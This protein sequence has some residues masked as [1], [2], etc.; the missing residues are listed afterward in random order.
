VQAERGSRPGRQ[1][2]HTLNLSRRTKTRLATEVLEQC[3]F[4]VVPMLHHEDCQSAG[5]L[6]R[7]PQVKVPKLLLA[8]ILGL[9]SNGKVLN[10]TPRR[11]N[12]LT[13]NY[14]IQKP[15]SHSS[16]SF[17]PRTEHIG[18]PARKDATVGKL[19]LQHYS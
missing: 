7:C 15:Y 13:T 17:G 10:L 8:S 1:P 9:N 2:E 3:T 14:E 11:Q 19:Y 16:Q 5:F 6:A 4:S 18:K 12:S